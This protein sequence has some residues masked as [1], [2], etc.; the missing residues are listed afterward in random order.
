ML[1]DEDE[2]EAEQEQ[3]APKSMVEKELEHV[4]VANL[5]IKAPT[6]TAMLAEIEKVWF[7]VCVYTYVHK[8]RCEWQV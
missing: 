1:F 4:P 7:P 6:D 8:W 2:E 5:P 3:S